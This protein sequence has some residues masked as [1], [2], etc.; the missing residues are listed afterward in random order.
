MILKIQ[1]SLYLHG[2]HDPLIKSSPY[3]TR[4]WPENVYIFSSEIG[5]FELGDVN[6][7]G[8]GFNDYEFSSDALND[9][10]LDE[11]KINV[12][13]THGTLNGS[14]K[15]YFDIKESLLKNFDY[16]ALRSHTPI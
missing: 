6:V 10:D 3:N 12:L 4:E 7:Y 5:L 11:S 2:N 8:I 1:K 15:K 16:V 13:V 9:L 14:S